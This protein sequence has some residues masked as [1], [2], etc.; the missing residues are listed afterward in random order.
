MKILGLNTGE[1]N[2]SAALLNNGEIIFAVQEER[3]NRL[4]FTRKFPLNSIKYCLNKGKIKITDL[5]V[6]SVGW[7]PSAHMLKYNSSISEVR[8]LREYNLY[9]ISDNLFNITDRIPGD[10]TVVK[11]G[12]NKNLLEVFHIQHHLCHAANSFFLS[13]FKEAA[14]LTVDFKG[15]RQCTTWCIGK[16][17]KIKVLQYQNVPDSLGMLYT[18]FTAILG[19]RPDNDEWKVMAMSAYNIK[20]NEYIKK[21]KSTYRLLENGK[22]KLNS[23][24]YGFFHR[25]N[26]NLFTKSILKLLNIKSVA[27]KSSPSTKNIMI[28][29]ALQYCA[30]EIAT[31]YLK[32]LY[33][34]TKC[35]NLVLGGGFFMNSVFNGK[36]GEKTKFKNYF[37]PYAPTDTGNS[38]GSAL[39]TYHCIFNKPRKIISNS[40]LL[41]PNFTDKEI[42]LVLKKRKIKFKKI[43]NFA[44]VV[45]NECNNGGIVAYFRNKLEF[46]DR[47]LGCRSI[48]ADPRQ[49]NTKDKINKYIKYRENY[50]PFAPSVIEEKANI[51]FEVNKDYKCKYMEKVIPVRKKYRNQLQAVTHLDDSARLHTVNKNENNDFYK[52]L[53]EF[54]KLTNFPILL[55][56]SFNV[57]GEPIVNSPDDAISTFYN[58][59]LKILIIGDYL[60]KKSQNK[61][62]LN[63]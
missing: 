53:I 51:F 28:A 10:Y 47:S 60:I 26:K 36:I 20:C 17:N 45:A 21:I 43:K 59:K 15:E 34:I 38:I 24:Y 37:I 61:L 19:Y 52:I 54:E 30:E 14:I 35:K 40:A 12:N 48:I 33:K 55:N 56:T 16:N 31:H 58:C 5:D 29:K 13:N 7:N 11:H 1:I 3:L 9:T 4:K 50:R 27:Y 63:F 49:S 6:I 8:T 25:N 57:N 23:K 44:K 18:T 46:G 2:S 42:E 62:K 39:Y 32:H 41:G 22:L